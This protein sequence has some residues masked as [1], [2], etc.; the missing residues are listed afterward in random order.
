MAFQ[1]KLEQDYTPVGHPISSDGDEN[2]IPNTKSNFS[3]P[4]KAPK[5]PD[6]ELTPAQVSYFKFCFTG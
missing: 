1:V 5:T 4:G 6:S 3:L 2:F